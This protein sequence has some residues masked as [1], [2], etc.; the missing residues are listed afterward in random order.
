MSWSVFRVWSEIRMSGTDLKQQYR[1]CKYVKQVWK[2]TLYV[3]EEGE[4]IGNYL[5]QFLPPSNLL[6]CI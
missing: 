4:R 1:E 3:T 2:L 6:V 5:E